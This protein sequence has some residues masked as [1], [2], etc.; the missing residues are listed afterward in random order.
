MIKE[1]GPAVKTQI[2]GQGGTEVSVVGSDADEFTCFVED[3]LDMGHEPAAATRLAKSKWAAEAAIEAGVLKEDVNIRNERVNRILF[4]DQDKSINE[5][6]LIRHMNNVRQ[7]AKFL[8]D[9]E[10]KFLRK[11]STATRV[12]QA[13]AEWLE[14]MERVR[15]LHPTLEG[16]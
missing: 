6:A 15:N 5:L 11:K 1:Y 8:D 14:Q 12:S 10:M 4:P 16:V 2:V 9:V 7:A 13:N 3:F